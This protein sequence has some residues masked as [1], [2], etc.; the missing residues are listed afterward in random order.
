MAT[1]VFQI[2]GMSDRRC[3]RAISARIS[4]VPGVRT[5]EASLDTRTIRVTG[6][7]DPVE[8]RTAIRRA[9]YTATAIPDGPP[10][11]GTDG[12]HTPAMEVDR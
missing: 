1:Q 4:D 12:E 5:V 8:V 10:P 6:T 11:V 7:A 3:V 2:V 9:G